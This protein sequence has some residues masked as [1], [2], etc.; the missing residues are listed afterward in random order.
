MDKSMIC[1]RQA[2]PNFCE[3]FAPTCHDWSFVHHF[4]IFFTYIGQINKIFDVYVVALSPAKWCKI[5]SSFTRQYLCTKRSVEYFK[6]FVRKDN[7]CPEQKVSVNYFL[8]F[9]CFTDF[10]IFSVLTV[11]FITRNLTENQL[12][13][14]ENRLTS[15]KIA[16]Q[17]LQN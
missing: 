12:A 15:R 13:H 9:S 7:H 16:T 3:I 10:Y 17:D 14:K 4:G 6:H 1:F 2:W 11:I 5:S 8:H